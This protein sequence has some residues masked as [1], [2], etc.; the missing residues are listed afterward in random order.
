M[1]HYVQR[2][3]RHAGLGNQLSEADGAVYEFR[4]IAGQTG[5]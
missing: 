4:K 5:L 3:I 2:I 1:K